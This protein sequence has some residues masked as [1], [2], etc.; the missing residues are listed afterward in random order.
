MMGAGIPSLMAIGNSVATVAPWLLTNTDKTNKAKA[1]VHGAD[2][3]KWLTVDS[4]SVKW[5]FI[6]V[7]PNQ[8]TPNTAITARIPAWNTEPRV[9]ASPL[10]LHA[11][12][13]SAEADSIT[14]SIVCAMPIGLIAPSCSKA[15]RSSGNAPIT[16]TSNAAAKKIPTDNLAFGEMAI[17]VCCSSTSMYSFT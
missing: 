8:A 10:G 9:I 12:I 3:T 14:I 5:P 16:T 6:K 17:S 1:K 11:K 4:T 7:S 13:I 2:S 15:G